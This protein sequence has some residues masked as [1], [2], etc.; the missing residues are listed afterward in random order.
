[1]AEKGYAGYD[2]NIW[3]ALVMA[4][5]TPKPIQ[6]LLAQHML[7]IGQMP[8]VQEKMVS[9]GLVQ[10]KRTLAEFDR[11]IGTEIKGLAALVKRSGITPE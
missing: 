7:R 11:F 3:Y 8:D 9:Q 4:S 5:Q 6:Q 1:M 2:S 10:E